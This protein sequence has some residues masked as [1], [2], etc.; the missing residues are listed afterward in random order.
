MKRI[1]GQYRVL[2]V[3]NIRAD[4]GVMTDETSEDQR[5]EN[6]PV[7]VKS[8]LLSRKTIITEISL[9]LFAIVLGYIIPQRFTTSASDIE[10]WRNANSWLVPWIDSLGLD[11]IYT[12]P[13]FTILLMVFLLSLVLSSYDQIKTA[14]NITSGRVSPMGKST[15]TIKAPED[16][17]ISVIKKQ[18]YIRLGRYF[19]STRYVKHPWG[20]WGNA[21]LHIGLV[22]VIASSLIILLTEKRGLLH[23]VEEEIHFPGSPWVVEE[24]GLLVKDFTLPEAIKLEKVNVDFYETDELKHLSSDIMFINPQGN[25]SKYQLGINKTVKFKGVRLYQSTVF[26]HAFFVEL[27]DPLGRKEKIILHIDHPWKRDRASYEDFRVEGIPYPVRAS[28]YVDAERR[29]MK[30]NNPLLTLLI[31]ED[32]KAV[33]EVTLK[34]GESKPLGPYTARLAYVSKWSEII[35]VKN[36]GM[37]GIFLGFSIIAVGV[38]LIY[39]TPPREF[40]ISKDSKGF[41]LSW[42]V[43]NFE[44]F[45]INEYEKVINT[46]KRKD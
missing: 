3:T 46:F 33:H 22:V 7:I 1:A 37:S 16:K 6:F 5:K 20:Y 34:V 10:K 31:V 28:Y 29:S 45:F 23:L 36:S 39:F 32:D 35:F 4:R 44:R 43:S 42:R 15:I 27:T 13:L 19:N 40:L 25:F 24:T 38:I 11:H 14:F 26:G 8:V 30:S 17:L 41:I 9:I 2:A 18:G 21:M 12:T